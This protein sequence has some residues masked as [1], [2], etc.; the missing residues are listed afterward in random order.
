MKP[1]KSMKNSPPKKPLLQINAFEAGLIALGAAL[2]VSIGYLVSL[3]KLPIYLDSIGTVFIS[4]LCGWQYGVI[5]GL[6]AV[7]VLAITA[8]PTILAYCGTAIVIALFSAAL[9]RFGF[10]KNLKAT[11]IGG[12]II[13]LGSAAASAP[14]TTLVFGGVSIAGSDA[15]TAL[16]K[17]SGFSLWQS[18]LLGKI[19]VD[20]LDK[21]FTAL[22][23]YSLVQ[24]LPSRMLERLSKRRTSIKL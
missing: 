18:V 16:F 11:I 3:L 23:C 17:A 14:V 22:I 8:I 21:I 24:S 4:A 13:G 7:I 5:V 10:L 15:I 19:I 1:A 20:P 2:N 12:L 6:S 9:V